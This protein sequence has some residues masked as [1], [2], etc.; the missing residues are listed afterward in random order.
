MVKTNVDYKKSHLLKSGYIKFNEGLLKRAIFSDLLD[1]MEELRIKK[2]KEIAPTDDEFTK[3][4]PYVISEYYKLEDFYEQIRN[5][6]LLLVQEFTD[7]EVFQT[8]LL[9]EMNKL[10]ERKQDSRILLDNV[11]QILSLL[12]LHLEACTENNPNHSSKLYVKDDNFYLGITLE[13]GNANNLPPQEL[14]NSQYLNIISQLITDLRKASRLPSYE[15]RLAIRLA[16]VLLEKGHRPDGAIIPWGN[17]GFRDVQTYASITDPGIGH[18]YGTVKSNQDLQGVIVH[19]EHLERGRYQDRELVEPYRIPNFNIIGKVKLN[20]GNDAPSSSYVGRPLF[21]SDFKPSAVKTVH[22]LSAACSAIFMDGLTECKLAIENMT[23]SEAI[24]FLKYMAGNVRRDPHTQ[25]LAAAFNIN[26]PILDDREKTMNENDGKPKLITDRFEIGMI[27]I[28]IVQEGGFE[29]VTWDGTANTYPSKCVIEQ[30]SFAEA[31]TLVHRAHEK[32]LIT[33]FSAGFRFNHLPQVIYTGTDGIGLGGAQILRYMDKKTGYHGPFKEENISKIIEIREKVTNDTKGKAAIL[34]SRL[35]RMY[36]EKCITPE[37]NE[38]RELL[39]LQLRDNQTDELVTTI[40][41]LAHI[42]SL[43]IDITHPLAS[44]AQRLVLANSTCMAAQ[45]F[46]SEN[47]WKDF[48]DYLQYA[49]DKHDY[50]LL[51][52]LLFSIQ[53]KKVLTKE[54]ANV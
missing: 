39:F 9:H 54:P 28:E 30:L 32:G 36:F 40:Q 44:W 15:E 12:N 49:V 48:V 14:S 42:E 50:D 6:L 53:N 27:G 17:T 52:E 38:K 20:V 34:L 11:Y 26:T 8:L 25:T 13:T 23:A 21:E 7:L 43:P 2:T 45:N 46:D 29:K 4:T 31:L 1:A 47:Q 33:Y 35:D 51:S 18:L 22:T 19:I 24:Q 3:N 10:L 16:Y 5:E 41:D 37:D